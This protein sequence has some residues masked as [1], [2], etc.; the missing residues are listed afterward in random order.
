MSVR[1]VSYNIRK[2]KGSYHRESAWENLALGLAGRDADLV[3]CQEVFHT[4]GKSGPFQSQELATTLALQPA[5]QPNATYERGHHGN[6]T[7]S[8]FGFR[9]FCN[10]DLSTNFVERRGVL[11]SLVETHLGPLH[12]WNTHLGLNRFQ[13]AKQVARIARLLR[14]YGA[15]NQPVLLAGDFNDWTGGLDRAIQADCGLRNALEELDHSRR[16]SWPS[17]RPVFGLDRIYY[18]GLRLRAI[19]VLSEPPW[20]GFSDHLPIEAEFTL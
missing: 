15:E 3:L 10:H 20:D 2:G 12:V 1:I 16:R 4:W 8:R 6:A 14:H 13:R 19:Q 11:F 18:R 17:F 7:L 9:H 5:Y